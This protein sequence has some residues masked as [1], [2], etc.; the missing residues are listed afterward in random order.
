M[1]SQPKNNNIIMN[2]VLTYSIIFDFTVPNW[3]STGVH[4]IE[5]RYSGSFDADHAPSSDSCQI[6]LIINGNIIEITSNATEMNR[7][8]GTL[9]LDASILGDDPTGQ[10]ITLQASQNNGSIQMI[11]EETIL[12]S[13]QYSYTFHTDN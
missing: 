8:D 4:T 5:A 6:Q 1:S 9:Q 12:N 10:T 7:E 2:P 11:L 13:S 3:Y